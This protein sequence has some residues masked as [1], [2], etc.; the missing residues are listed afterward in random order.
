MF[1]VKNVMEP[2]NC[3]LTIKLKLFENDDISLIKC[4]SLPLAKCV[5]FKV[6]WGKKMFHYVCS[7]MLY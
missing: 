5:A 3:F 1:Y 6:L 7:G 4:T 2:Q